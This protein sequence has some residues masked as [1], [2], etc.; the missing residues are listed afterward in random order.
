MNG[1]PD[2]PYARFGFKSIF[3]A[4]IQENTA[5]DELDAPPIKIVNNIDDDPCPDP[6]FVYTNKIIYGEGVSPPDLDALQ[7][8]DCEGPCDPN[9]KTCTCIH[10]QKQ[11]ST[12]E[13]EGFVHND[14]GI[15]QS[16]VEPL[17]IVECNSACRCSIACQNRI[18]QRGR[19][20]P[21]TIKKTREKGWGSFARLSKYLVW[22]FVGLYAG[23]LLTDEEAEER[24]IVY[25]KG[26][27][28]YLFD[29]DFYHIKHDANGVLVDDGKGHHSIDA[30]HYGNF[31]RF[32]N[33]SCSPNLTMHAAYINEVDVQKPLLVMYSSRKID[34][35]E[36]LCFSYRGTDD[37]RDTRKERERAGDQTCHCGSKNCR[38]YMF[39]GRDA[40]EEDGE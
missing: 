37:E 1:L 12:N 24:G 9:S 3:E 8:C 30:Y 20:V 26:P 17:V 38:G 31:T 23:E 11:Y 27:C 21:I 19:T 25:D 4:H 13:V 34:A 5:L 15:L 14:K 39:R 36:E 33:H 7:G 40:D 18:I 6:T 22:T 32:L 2:T 16:E 10:R 29:V 35:G 28:T